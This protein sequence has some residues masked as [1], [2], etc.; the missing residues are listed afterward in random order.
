VIEPF[1]SI[2][3]N[4]EQEWGERLLELLSAA[5]KRRLMSDVPLGFFLSGGVDSSSVVAM[6]ER[7]MDCA[8]MHTFSIG[9]EEKSFD[10]SAY[11]RVV[12]ERLGTQH[13]TDVL[14]IDKARSLLPE[15]VRRLD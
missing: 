4:P 10:E 3:A 8:Q 7:H 2:P 9:F 14:S 13:H 15:I 11:A 1:D 5:V 6:A 12:A